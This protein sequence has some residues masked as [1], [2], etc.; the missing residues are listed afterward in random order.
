LCYIS[1][2][3]ICFRLYIYYFFKL[4]VVV[5]EKGKKLSLW[6]YYYNTAI[7]EYYIQVVVGTM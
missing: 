7:L 6:C 5:C 3:N 4:L 2:Q 1:N